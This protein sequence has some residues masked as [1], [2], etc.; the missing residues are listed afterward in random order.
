MSKT[1]IL[2]LGS[3]SALVLVQSIKTALFFVLPMS[4][5][6]GR[7]QG[8][9]GL[10]VRV[11][12]G[13]MRIWQWGMGSYSYREGDGEI[14]VGGCKWIIFILCLSLTWKRYWFTVSPSWTIWEVVY[15]LA[16]F[17]V[18]FSYISLISPEGSAK[19]GGRG[20]GNIIFFR[21]PRNSFR[22][23]CSSVGCC[24]AQ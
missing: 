8:L 21:V 3:K 6:L 20:T 2:F 11:T 9:E 23:R 24:V 4:L 15:T 13:G 10:Q 1:H 7:E 16:D 19:L 5:S 18:G 22:V 12:H 17:F 14:G